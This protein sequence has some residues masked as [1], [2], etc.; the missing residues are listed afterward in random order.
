MDFL[1]LFSCFLNLHFMVKIIYSS[2]VKN[3]QEFYIFKTDQTKNKNLVWPLLLQKL[4]QL[5]FDAHI[6]LARVALT[7]F[8]HKFL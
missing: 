8:I 6:C 3:M 2:L 7:Y 1:K 4:L 5:K